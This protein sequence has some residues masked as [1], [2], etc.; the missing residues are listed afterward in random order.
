MPPLPHRLRIPEE[1]KGK[2]EK[3][4]R[5]KGKGK[6]EKEKEKKK[7]KKK[8][9]EKEKEKGRTEEGPRKDRAMKSLGTVVLK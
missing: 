5:K 2:K 3:E 9:K 8:E 6:K 4:E 7:E 1:V